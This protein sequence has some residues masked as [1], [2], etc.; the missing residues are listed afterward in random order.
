MHTRVLLLLLLDINSFGNFVELC[1]FIPGL[2]P[3]VWSLALCWFAVLLDII[4]SPRGTL[5]F[6]LGLL[7][8]VCC[9]ALCRFAVLLSPWFCR[10]LLPRPLLVCCAAFY[11]SFAAC[12]GHV[13]GSALL[14]RREI[15]LLCCLL[16]QSQIWCC[17]FWDASRSYP[18]HHGRY[19]HSST[20][21]RTLLAKRQRRTML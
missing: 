15:Y 16:A 10:C 7:P 5:P 13:A 1:P 17:E 19:I 14:P 3:H 20:T 6:I 11:G 8:L 2:L 12:F 4:S 21:Q 9:L 18:R